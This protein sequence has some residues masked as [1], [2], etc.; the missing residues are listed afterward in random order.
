MDDLPQALDPA[1][2][3]ELE[4]PVCMDCMVPP[5]TLCTNGH[6]ICR[7]CRE[8][9]QL[10]PICRAELSEIR[11]VALENIARSQKYP[12]ANRWRGCLELFSCEHIAEH[13]TV[14]EYGKIGCP[15]KLVTICSWKGLQ[16]DLKEHVKAEH[17]GNYAEASKIRSVGFEDDTVNITSCFGQLFVQYK[18]V[19]DGRLYSAIQLV[20]TSNQASKYK[21]EFTLCAE[22]GIEQISKILLVRGDSEDVETIFNSGKCLCLDEA[23]VRHY[24]VENKLNMTITLLKV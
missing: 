6:N 17:P 19:R 4:C 11:N 20:G 1:V 3:K 13:H 15:F 24:I 8:N 14:C 10:C 5:I 7:Q 21:C 22:N 9:V 12:C 23:V 18:R 16:S 2:L